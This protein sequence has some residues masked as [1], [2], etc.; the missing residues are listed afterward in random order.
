LNSDGSGIV[1]LV[2]SMGA[3]TTTA[4]QFVL[5]GSEDAANWYVIGANLTG[6]ASSTVAQT[7]ATVFSK[8]LRARVAV[9]GVG[10]TL[11]YVNL[12]SN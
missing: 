1:N 7:Y 3:I 4:P 11:G 9:A 10:A 2:V 5:E 12:K 6:V 8:F